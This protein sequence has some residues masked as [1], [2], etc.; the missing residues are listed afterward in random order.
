MFGVKA[1]HNLALLYEGSGR[2]E[3]A[4]EAW[5]AV[6]QHD[7]GNLAGWWG[8]LG[9]ACVV[10]VALPVL[11]EGARFAEVRLAAPACEAVRAG[12]TDAAFACFEAAMDGAEASVALRD[13][14]CRVAFRCGAWDQAERWLG[15]LVRV[16]PDNAS[17]WFNLAVARFQRGGYAGAVEA[18]RRSLALRPGYR[19]AERL[20]GDAEARLAREAEA[21][22]A[23]EAAR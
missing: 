11:P 22:P 21:R 23:G 1:W 8:L 18:V 13:L 10:P 2:P 4:A 20:L 15:G 7:A 9:A 14:A 6:L 5:L 3:A 12:R 19:A 16:T 17:A